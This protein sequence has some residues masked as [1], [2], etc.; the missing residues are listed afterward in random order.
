MQILKL[1]KSSEEVRQGTLIANVVLPQPPSIPT[2]QCTTYCIK[3]A[4]NT[5][6][7][8]VDMDGIDIVD[9]R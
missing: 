4:R 5:L 8:Y 6:F 1:R 3:R 7:R 2:V 9:V